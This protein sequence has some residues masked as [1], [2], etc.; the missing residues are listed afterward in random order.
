M[1]GDILRAA[2]RRLIQSAARGYVTLTEKMREAVQEAR[3]DQ[4][5]EATTAHSTAPAPSPAR[6]RTKRAS[7]T[8]AKR[9]TTAKQKAPSESLSATAPKKRGRKPR[10]DKPV[11][12]R[13]TRTAKDGREEKPA[14]QS[15]APVVEQPVE[16]SSTSSPRT[17]NA[18]SPRTSSA[19]RSSDSKG[20]TVQQPVKRRGRPRKSEILT[21]QTAMA[22]QL[23][24]AGNELGAAQ[25]LRQEQMLT[26]E[27]ALVAEHATEADRSPQTRTRKVRPAKEQPASASDGAEKTDRASGKKGRRKKSESAATQTE[28]APVK[29]R[30]RS[31]KPERVAAQSDTEARS[32]ASNSEV[33]TGEVMPEEEKQPDH[34]Q[35]D[36]PE[37]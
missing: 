6:A 12:V 33:G 14:V 9:A 27:A 30:R 28:A 24:A 20:E 36:L 17:R 2:Q 21:P 7:S 31:R 8:T 13:R 4:A 10:A 37:S 16:A 22:G 23:Q 11:T 26:T 32:D 35:H 3:Q 18:R 34:E 19:K 15:E 5:R 29:K 25:V 1:L